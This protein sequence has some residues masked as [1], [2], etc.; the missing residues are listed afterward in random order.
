MKAT[1]ILVKEHVLIEQVL[2]SLCVTREK[3]EKGERPPENFLRYY[4]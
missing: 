2:N 1:E 4:G 3:L